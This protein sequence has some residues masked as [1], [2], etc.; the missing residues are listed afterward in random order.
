M[1]IDQRSLY[2]E[3]IAYINLEGKPHVNI[4]TMKDWALAEQILCAE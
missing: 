4:D 1:I 3:R 2:G